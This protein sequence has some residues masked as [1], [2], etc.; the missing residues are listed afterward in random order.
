MIEEKLLCC[1]KEDQ[2]LEK[3]YRLVN[4][5]YCIGPQTAMFIVVLTRGFTLFENPRKFACYCVL[6]PF[7]NTSG[8]TLKGKPRVSHLANKKIKTLL[9]MCALNTIKTDNE[10]KRY[11]DRKLKEGKHHSAIFECN[12]K[13]AC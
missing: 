9:T 3:Q 5:V 11:Y 8:T 10:F 13:Q 2:V 7:G 1:I 12:Q 4:S 6:F